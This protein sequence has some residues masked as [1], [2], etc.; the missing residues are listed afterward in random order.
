MAQEPFAQTLRI[1][2]WKCGKCSQ[3]FKSKRSH[4]HHKIECQ[5]DER[6]DVLPVPANVLDIPAN[7]PFLPDFQEIDII[8]ARPCN[9]I[10]G[11][12]FASN[13]A[14]I[15]NEC[16][17]WRKNL[18]KL[19][20]GGAAKEF[21]KEISHWLEHFNRSTDFQGIALKVYMVLPSLLLQ[22]PGPKSK[23]KEHLAI[24]KRRLELWKNG[25]VSELLRECRQIQAKLK[26]SK[27]RNP[28]DAARIFAKLVFEGKIGA[29]LKFISDETE[30][31]ILDLTD[32]TLAGLAKKHP[33]PSPVADDTLLYGPINKVSTHELDAIDELSI[34]KA[35]QQTRGSSGPSFLDADQYRHILCSRKYKHEGKELRV[36]IAAF[37]KRIAT[38][39]IDPV[40]LEPYVSCRLIPLN[41]NPGIRPIGVGEVMRRIVGKA[42]SS[43]LQDDI[44]EAAG[45]LQVSA[46][47]KGGSEAAIH[48]MREIFSEEGCDG[49]ILVDASNAF[50]CLNRRAALHNIQITAPLFAPVLINTYRVPSRLFVTGGGEMVSQ[51]GTTQGDPLAMAFYGLSTLPLQN[52]LRFGEPEVKQ[53]WLADDAT[54]AGKLRSLRRWWDIMIEHGKRYG[55]YVN[56]E[57]SWLILSDPDLIELAT[58]IFAG[59]DIK[60]TTAGKRHLGAAI[61]TVDFRKE[62]V[63]EK[64]NKWSREVTKLANFAQSQ[65]H[66]AYAA[67]IH[68]EQHRFRFFMRTIPDMEEYLKPLDDVIKEKLIPAIIGREINNTERTLFSL[69]IREGGMGLPVLVDDAPQ[70]FIS[71]TTINAPLAAIIALQGSE[72]P[73]RDQ[74]RQIVQ[75]ERRRRTAEHRVKI[76]NIDKN[77]HADVLRAVQQAREPGV[78]NWLS[79]RPSEEHGFKLNKSEFRDAIAIRYNSPLK[80]IPSLCVCGK[81]FDTNH[82]LNCKRGGFVTIRHN[83]I[84]DFEA[85]LLSKVCNDV[86]TEPPLQPLTG[87]VLPTAGAAGDD[88]KAD[89]RAR[90]FWRPGQN[91]YFDVLVTNASAVSHANKPLKAVLAKYERS[92]KSKY[93]HR[94]MNIEHGTFTPLIFTTNGCMGPE[95][96]TYHKSIA[97]KISEKTGESYADVIS[98]IRCKLSFLLLRSTLLCIRGSRRPREADNLVTVGDDFVM[99]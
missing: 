4:E 45:P 31:G 26:S 77:L 54:G 11:Q 91:A 80:N 78:S 22:K 88:A 14:D 10:D 46:G 30:S 74:C 24:L 33:E 98:Y 73:G 82:A 3:T 48:S 8:P 95:C 50:N 87:E 57:K 85:A 47:Q 90:G 68:G 83:E 32:E 53:V 89:V 17:K 1:T 97:D 39:I 42:I 27:R 62:Y 69:P 58:E 84:R 7:E 55:Y 6:A 19:P 67:F 29:A 52:E 64:V 65:P 2:I 56:E 71:S 43:V 5:L 81:P 99:I 94:I 16:V 72:L 51:E 20:S 21:V 18:F 37:A 36:Q 23:A 38:E 76:E 9:S 66:A 79:V 70:E 49:V 44:Q 92:K 41:K 40:I 35:A 59:T 60:I 13:I 25:E 75:D 12:V 93:G 86:E 61:G 96:S 15:Y 63:S 28:D 34:L